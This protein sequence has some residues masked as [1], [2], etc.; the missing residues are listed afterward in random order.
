M[1]AYEESKLLRIIEEAKSVMNARVYRALDCSA[2]C[3]EDKCFFCSGGKPGKKFKFRITLTLIQNGRRTDIT[4]GTDG[5][6]Y[7]H[8]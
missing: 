6:S 7:G 4:S 1:S 2:F 8:V 5:Y 3:F